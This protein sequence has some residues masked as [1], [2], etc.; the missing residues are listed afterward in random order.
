M[1]RQLF[2]RSGL[3]LFAVLILPACGGKSGG[4]TGPTGTV[5]GKVTMK[6]QPVANANIVF[7]GTR[8]DT[9]V[10]TLGADGTYSL[11]YQAGFSVPVGDYRVAIT[12]GP[13]PDAPVPNP[14][15]IMA[16]PPVAA[17]DK[18]IPDKYRDPGTSNLIAV[19]KEGSNSG[20]DF[21]LQ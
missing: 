3:L 7:Y 5:T 8:G 1:R 6:G 11:R 10:G 9:A 13:A 17:V 20:V 18:S 14:E 12:K 19:V 16:K 2:V 21:D 4:L 15:D